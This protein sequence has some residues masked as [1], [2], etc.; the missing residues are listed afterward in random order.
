MVMKKNITVKELINLLN[1]ENNLTEFATK[2][3]K[4][5]GLLVNDEFNG[6]VR[7][8]KICTSIKNIL[9][10]GIFLRFYTNIANS[11]LIEN[12]LIKKNLV[13]ELEE[14]QKIGTVEECKDAMEIYR[15]MKYYHNNIKKQ[16]AKKP[17]KKKCTFNNE[18]FGCCRR[19]IQD[20]INHA[21][22]VENEKYL[23][24][25]LCYANSGNIENDKKNDECVECAKEYGQLAKWL[26]ELK[27]YCVKLRKYDGDFNN[28]LSYKIEEA[29][30]IINTYNGLEEN[31]QLIKVSL[32]LNQIVF[33]KHRGKITKGKVISIIYANDKVQ[34]RIEY[35]ED[36]ISLPRFF[37]FLDEDINNFVFLKEK[38]AINNNE[39]PW[40]NIYE[41]IPPEN[42]LLDVMFEDVAGYS[43]IQ[44]AVFCDGLWFLPNKDTY[45]YDMPI[46]WR[47]IVE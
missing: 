33:F 26:D 41:R 14:Y 8:V 15:I 47:Y 9:S 16:V 46:Y 2:R 7:D 17:N 44:E 28:K 18:R 25:F 34:Y 20:A 38:E 5:F 3:D 32:S 27:E 13:G 42:I 12:E 31:G 6:F 24:G 22:E 11:K 37:T 35:K 21:K 1:K 29:I 10:E 40:I 23:Q 19:I 36:G 4:G 30:N 45:V 43:S 39:M